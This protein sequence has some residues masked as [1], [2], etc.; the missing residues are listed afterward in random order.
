MMEMLKRFEEAQTE[1]DEALEQ[2]K[3]Q[4]EEDQ[5]E[6]E[7]VAA[8]GD[9]DLGKFFLRRIWKPDTDE[10]C[11]QIPSI[12]TNS[13]AYYLQHT[14][15]RFLLL[16]AIRIRTIPEL[17]WREQLWMIQNHQMSCLGGKRQLRSKIRKT[18]IQE[19]LLHLKSFQTISLPQSC[20]PR[21]RGQ[22]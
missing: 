15:M 9:I 5:P 13:C 20:R 4:E 14:V 17:C 21:E 8:L 10:W 3:K 11:G 6:D 1:G 22:N 7:L 2:L 12:R 19:R 16:S 18:A